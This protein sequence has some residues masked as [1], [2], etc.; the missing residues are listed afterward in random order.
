MTMNAKTTW[1]REEATE[2]KPSKPANDAFDIWDNELLSEE[3]SKTSELEKRE[4]TFNACAGM[5]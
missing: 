5:F 1:V 2:R 4:A 3:T